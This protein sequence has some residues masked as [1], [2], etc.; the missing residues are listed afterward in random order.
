[1]KRPPNK[2]FGKRRP[3]PIPAASAQL[4]KRSRHVAL[5]VMGS[6]A[7]GGGAY[8]LM[9][10]E[11]CE[12]KGAGMAGPSLP[13]TDTTCATRGSSSGHGGSWSRGSF[14]SA[15]PSSNQS[16]SGSSSESGSGQV[17]RGGFGGFARAFAA[18][19]S[20]S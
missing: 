13:Q 8:A 20:G 10:R 3:A 2:E 17:T 19:F 9:P 5:L 15:G 18:H 12:P 1:M 6:L 7:I 16:S 14:F 4:V 11:T